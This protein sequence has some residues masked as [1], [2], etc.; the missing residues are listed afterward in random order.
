[1]VIV[2]GHIMVDPEQREAYLDSCVNVVELARDASG[3]LDFAITADVL[4][5]GRIDIFEHWDSQAAAEAFRGSG[6]S[7]EQAA[8][9]LSASVSEYDIAGSRSLT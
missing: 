5:P 7:D 8:T 9:V 2:A 1:M 3:C 4:D 6:P